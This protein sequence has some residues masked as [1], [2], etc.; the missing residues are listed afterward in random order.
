MN[1][2]TIIGNLTHDPETRSAGSGTVCNFTVAVNAKIKGEDKSTFFRVAAWNKLGEVC[3]QYLAKGRKVA[4]I[5]EVSARAY[6]A[7][8][9]NAACSLELMAQDV[10]FLT[11]RGEAQAQAPQPDASGFTELPDDEPLPF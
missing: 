8:D 6:T 5:G 1:K 10:E 2:T 3:Q 11:P 7:K 9:G 4:V